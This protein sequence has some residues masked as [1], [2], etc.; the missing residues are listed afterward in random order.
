MKKLSRDREKK[1]AEEPDLDEPE[2]DESNEPRE[3]E[4]QLTAKE[5]TK[6]L[7]AMAKDMQGM[8]TAIS[9]LG[10][11]TAYL[12]RLVLSKPEVGKEDSKNK[13]P[14]SEGWLTK[15][16]QDASLGELA[17]LLRA[18]GDYDI[19]RRRLSIEPTETDKLLYDL[20]KSSVEDIR[21]ARVKQ[22]LIAKGEV[23]AK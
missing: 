16:V 6:I 13:D 8:N 17:E 10:N 2:M 12:K 5:Q 20:G 7:I 23:I 4:P 19:N 11:D 22:D 9:N 1:S 3:P 18:A 21:R 14:R 15:K